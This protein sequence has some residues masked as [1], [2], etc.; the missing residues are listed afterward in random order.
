MDKCS[1]TLL[2]VGCGEG[3]V[4][5]SLKKIEKNSTFMSN[6]YKI[7]LDLFRPALNIAKHW[8]IYDSYILADA[9]HLPLKNESIDI[10]LAFDLI[11]HL[12]KNEGEDL[13]KSLEEIACKQVII[14]TPVGFLPQYTSKDNP[15]QIHK[16][17]WLPKEFK[18]RGYRVYGI[19]GFAFIT[20]VAHFT[21]M[22]SI[23]G[24]IVLLLGLL[25][26]PIV[27]LIPRLAFQMICIKNL[28]EHK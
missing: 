10:V 26:Q 24:V 20:Q 25:T 2:D 28:R 21:W 18:I 22:K 14:F 15:H 11:E 8:G 23:L 6:C 4:I 5:V 9:R 13:I 17:G 3:G 27:Y 16:S 12:N 1:N 7:G 19:R